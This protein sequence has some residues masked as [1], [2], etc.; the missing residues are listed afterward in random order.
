MASVE[1][2]PAAA[3][4]QQPDARADAGSG[5][6]PAPENVPSRPHHSVSELLAALNKLLA[7][8]DFSRGDIFRD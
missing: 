8:S 5:G 7:L 4:G 3:R 1:A 2:P 6:T